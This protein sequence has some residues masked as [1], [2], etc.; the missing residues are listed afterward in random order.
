MQ[1]VGVVGL[2]LDVTKISQLGHRLVGEALAANGN[3]DSLRR[4]AEGKG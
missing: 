1:S 4:D 3:L 2:G